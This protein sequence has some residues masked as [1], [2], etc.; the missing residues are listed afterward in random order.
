MTD[1]EN[2]KIESLVIEL[3]K[4]KSNH[5]DGSGRNLKRLL[6]KIIRKTLMLLAV[7]FLV[8]AGVFILNFFRLNSD[9]IDGHI[10]E[11]LVPSLT[12]GQFELEFGGI[13]GNL[14]K[15]VELDSVVIKNKYI[16]SAATLLTVPRIALEYSLLDVLLGNL[17][18]EN[19]IIENLVITLNREEKSRALL[20]I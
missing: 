18:L 15:G 19:I 4:R 12:N 10:K 7:A 5:K 16:D 2:K 13:S 9:L 8:L 6:R 3:E 11:G 14:L 1:N 20:D 17:V